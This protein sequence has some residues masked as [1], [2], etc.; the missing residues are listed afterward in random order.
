MDEVPVPQG[1][2]SVDGRVIP[3]VPLID[4][5]LKQVSARSMEIAVARADLQQMTETCAALANEPEPAPDGDWDGKWSKWFVT[6]PEKYMT[7][8][9]DWLTA[10]EAAIIAGRRCVASR[11]PGTSTMGMMEFEALDSALERLGTVSVAL[12]RSVVTEQ[13]PPG[14]QDSPTSGAED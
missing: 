5:L 3:I 10:A 11:V 7:V 4:D 14:A 9:L 2:V 8:H 6:D 12:G 13:A 1:Y